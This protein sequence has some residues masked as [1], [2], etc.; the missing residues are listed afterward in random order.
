MSAGRASAPA[1][2]TTPSRSAARSPPTCRRSSGL[3]T[4]CESRARS[5]ARRS[6]PAAGHPCPARPRRAPARRVPGWGGRGTPIGPASG[7]PGPTRPR[8]SPTARDVRTRPRP[9]EACE[10]S[11]RRRPARGNRPRIRRTA[12]CPSRS[13]R[14]RAPASPVVGVRA[15]GRRAG[16]ASLGHS[17]GP[18]RRHGVRDRRAAD[19]RPRMARRP[20]DAVPVST[21]HPAA[22]RVRE[23]MTAS[24]K[25]SHLGVRRRLWPNPRPIPPVG[26][27][28]PSAHFIRQRSAR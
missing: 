1:P 17:D 21:P 12:V 15:L 10:R 27:D 14:R 18:S 23:A 20:A 4:T 19:V 26:P 8:R 7:P 13:I 6:D 28:A 16:E 2:R 25:S 9:D 5:E 11:G 24:S 22:V 3:P